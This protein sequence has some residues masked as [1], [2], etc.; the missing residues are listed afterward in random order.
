MEDV[1]VRRDPAS[2]TG[3]A[4]VLRYGTAQL[5]AR[6]LRFLGGGGWVE[7]R[8]ARL[9]V[10]PDEGEVAAALAQRRQQT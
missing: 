6:A 4:A 10:R 8:G 1:W 9:V 2:A 3:R 7:L 5:A